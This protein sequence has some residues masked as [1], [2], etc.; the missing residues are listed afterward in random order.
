MRP[1]RRIITSSPINPQHQGRHF[2]PIRHARILEN[3]HYRTSPPDASFMCLFLFHSRRLTSQNPRI[4][5]PESPED[6]PKH[7]SN[8]R[9]FAPISSTN[10]GGDPTTPLQPQPQT[11]PASTDPTARPTKMQN[12]ETNLTPRNSLHQKALDPT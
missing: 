6:G 1:F 4:K 3:C 5:V 9:S 12:G 7:D 2:Q 11:Q 10:T 8:S